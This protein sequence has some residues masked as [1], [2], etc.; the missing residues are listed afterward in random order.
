[1]FKFRN[2][3][4]KEPSRVEALLEELLSRSAPSAPS[5]SV[6]E[7]PE[8]YRF[9]AQLEG[10]QHRVAE[11]ESDELIA[12]LGKRVSALE[13]RIAELECADLSLDQREAARE[14][15]KE[16]AEE[17][18]NGE[19]FDTLFDARMEYHN[20]VDE[21]HCGLIEDLDSA[22][23]E[24]NVVREN[25]L[26]EVKGE[27]WEELRELRSSSNKGSPFDDRDVELLESLCRFV[28]ERE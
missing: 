24:E 11:L 28:R 13:K 23:S 21:D 17:A 15:A 6:E 22:L 2:F 19:A 26:D 18:L 10:L 27:I 12:A 9:I 8:G 16:A 7:A 25:D 3:F 4:R 1:M 20:L 5:A 14:V